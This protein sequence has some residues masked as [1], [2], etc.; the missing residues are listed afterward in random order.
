MARVKL[1]TLI[2]VKTYPIPSTK[3]EELVCTAGVTKEGDF[4]RLYPINF[5]ELPFSQQYRKY[6][7]IE[8]EATRHSGRDIRKESYRPD[9]NTLVTLTDPIPPNH[10]DWSERAKFALAKKA[11]S[12]ED[13]VDRQARDQT[14]LG[15]FRPHV[16]HDLKITN[17]TP[18]WKPSFLE[19]L[20]QARLWEHQARTKEPPRK[21]PYKFQYCFQ[22]DDTRCKGNHC[23][24]IEDWEVGALYWKLIDRGATPNQAAQGVREKFL[25]EICRPQNDTHFF[26]GTTLAHPKSWLILGVFYPR[27]DAKPVRMDANLRLFEE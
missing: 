27:R 23:M 7:W 12:M 9:C 19:A 8:V 26:V 11:T 20:R 13:L 16:V 10:G 18:A 1:K 2:T 14:S 17:V 6:Q 24:M 3:Y 5:R 22:C 4:V 21:V 25:T 15:V